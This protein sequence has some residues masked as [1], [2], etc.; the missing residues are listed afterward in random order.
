MFDGT[1]FP[2]ARQTDQEA[3]GRETLLLCSVLSYTYITNSRSLRN[4]MIS[5]SDVECNVI[6]KNALD[7]ARMSQMM[8]IL[9]ISYICQSPFPELDLQSLLCQT[10]DVRLIL[11]ARST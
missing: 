4:L 10:R 2:V 3:A 11:I 5:V 1:L 9:I 8:N 6:N 7:T